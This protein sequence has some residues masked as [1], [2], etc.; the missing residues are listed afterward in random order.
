MRLLL[1]GTAERLREGY[2]PLLRS[3]HKIIATA[4][5][6]ETLRSQAA[7]EREHL[8]ALLIVGELTED[9]TALAEL[10]AELAIPTGILLSPH[11]EA[12]T[13]AG[14]PHVLFLEGNVSWPVAA[15]ALANLAENL[16]PLPPQRA[17]ASAAPTPATT[18]LAVPPPTSPRPAPRPARSPGSSDTPLILHPALGGVGAST[19][20]LTLAAAGAEVGLNSLAVTADVIPLAARAGFPPAERHL[21]RQLGANLSAVV[22]EGPWDVP[23][24][25]AL[26]VWDMWRGSEALIQ[27]WPVLIVTRPTGDGRLAALQAAHEVPQLGGTVAGICLVGRG[28]LGEGE[29]IRLAREHRVTVPVWSLPDDPLVYLLN[30]EQGHGLEAPRYGAAVRWLARQL[31]PALAWPSEEEETPKRKRER[32]SGD[33]AKGQHSRRKKLIE[34][35]D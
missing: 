22:V 15:G 21:I 30:E 17:V 9:P 4:T 2:T 27:R 6:L 5:S 25:F 20:A 18:S 29:F 12:R 28:T 31:W 8:D 19:L 34:W 24:G 7:R 14:L 35:V 11:W 16:P 3:G 1:A 33:E 13:F 32:P 10:L 26:V 23:P